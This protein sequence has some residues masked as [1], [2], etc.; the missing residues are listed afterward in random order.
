MP[1]RAEAVVRSPQTFPGHVTLPLCCE[2][3]RLVLTR[4]QILHLLLLHSQGWLSRFPFQGYHREIETQL[5]TQ[6]I[7]FPTS[8]FIMKVDS[9]SFSLFLLWKKK[10][11]NLQKIPSPPGF[12]SPFPEPGSTEVFCLSHIYNDY[13]VVTCGR[14]V[15]TN[16]STQ[17]GS[18]LLC[19]RWSWCYL[20]SL[21]LMDQVFGAREKV[22]RDGPC[23]V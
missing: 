17:T 1:L 10:A 23:S 12:I 14:G 3:P 11:H 2:G 4:T 13:W 9:V 15:H 7:L 18:Y 20:V 16:L 22:Q 21:F 19:F 8:C 5:A 6:P